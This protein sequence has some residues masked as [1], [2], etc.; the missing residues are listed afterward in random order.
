MFWALNDKEH[1]FYHPEESR[2]FGY[3]TDEM[4][5][6]FDRVLGK[7]LQGV[8]P[9]VPV[10]V[11]SDHGFGPFRREVNINNWLAQEGYLKLTTATGGRRGLDPGIRRLAGQQGLRPGPERPLPEHE[12]PGTRRH[13]SAPATGATCWKRSRPAGGHRRPQERPEGHL[14]RLHLRGQFLQG[15]SSTAP[16]T[17]SWALTAATASATS[18]PWAPSAAR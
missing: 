8:G 2:K 18:R 5:R 3:I 7:A 4:Y 11:M 9:D 13:A 10:L 16:R 17:S 14:L 1:P 6:K 15:P 12:G